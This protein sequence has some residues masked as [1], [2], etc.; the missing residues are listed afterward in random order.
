MIRSL[1]FSIQDYL[2]SIYELTA[3][4]GAAGTNA[5]AQRLRVSPASVT[6]MVQKLASLRP[7][8]V[9]YKKHR[10]VR[11][12]RRGAR[13]ALEVIRHHRLLEAWLVQSLGYSWD[14]VHGDAEKLEHALSDSLERRIDDALGNPARDPHGE[15]IPSAHLVMPVDRSVALAGLA[16]GQEAVVRRV[17]SED[18]AVLRQLQSLGLVIGAHLLSMDKPRR[19]GVMRLQVGVR[20][21]VVPLGPTVTRSVYV[22]PIRRPRKLPLG[23]IK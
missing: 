9:V 20:K 17:R 13:A 14:E 19:D 5:L 18:A 15:P 22:Q 7:A 6:G 8:L 12:T 23:R 4:G 16:A 11:L 21:Q 10:G 1:T 3:D 2:K